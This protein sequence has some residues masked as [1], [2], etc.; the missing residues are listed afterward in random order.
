RRDSRSWSGSAARHGWRCGLRL[1][2]LHVLEISMSDLDAFYR[3]LERDAS[4]DDGRFVVALTDEDEANAVAWAEALVLQH[5]EPI[6]SIKPAE[7]DRVDQHVQS[8]RAKIALARWLDLPF[9]GTPR[10]RGSRYQ[11]ET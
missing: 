6:G 3:A 2:P 9:D 11:R 8:L 10:P 7:C 5:P 4:T 1:A